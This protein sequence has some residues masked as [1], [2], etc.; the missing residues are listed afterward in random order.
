MSTT[1]KTHKPAVR[2]L[3]NDQAKKMFDRKA[4]H[5]LKMSGKAFIKKWDAGLFNGEA[6]TPAVTRVAMLLP[7]GR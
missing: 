4:K 3:S 5:Y 6:D 7:F 2:E 1:T